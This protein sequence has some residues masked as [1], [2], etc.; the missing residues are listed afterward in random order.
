MVVVTPLWLR[1]GWRNVPPVQITTASEGFPEGTDRLAN[2]ERK[3]IP[4]NEITGHLFRKTYF[5]ITIPDH[6]L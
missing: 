4:E 3:K 6:A 2:K 5:C 1:T